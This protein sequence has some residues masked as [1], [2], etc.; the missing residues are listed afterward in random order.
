[1]RTATTRAR[2]RRGRWNARC[3][4]T[5]G[6]HLISCLLIVEIHDMSEVLIVFYLPK[7][8]T[9]VPLW[10]LSRAWYQVHGRAGHWLT[11]SVAIILSSKP[12]SILVCSSTLNY[13]TVPSLLSPPET[14]LVSLRT[15][16]GRVS[17]AYVRRQL[18]ANILV[19]S[20]Q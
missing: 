16:I 3:S 10:Q 6:R 4:L 5:R 14:S 20:N 11:P 13:S 15:V 1:M 19:R 17:C 8:A 2:A 7:S 12:I 9:I 18:L